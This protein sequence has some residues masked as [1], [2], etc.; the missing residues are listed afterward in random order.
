MVIWVIAGGKEKSAYTLLQ[1]KKTDSKLPSNRQHQKQK[2]M[3][4]NHTTKKLKLNP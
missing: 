2:F 4:K 3:Y 1:N